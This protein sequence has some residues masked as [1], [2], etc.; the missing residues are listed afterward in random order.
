LNDEQDLQKKED[1]KFFE[2]SLDMIRKKVLEKEGNFE[3][4]A[5]FMALVGASSKRISD[6][7]LIYEVLNGSCRIETRRLACRKFA[8]ADFLEQARAVSYGIPRA[9]ES[10]DILLNI[11]SIS[12][13]EK[14]F[15]RVSEKIEDLNREIPILNEN[16]RRREH[17]VRKAKEYFVEALAEAGKLE[18]ALR[19]IERSDEK[20]RLFGRVSSII[21]EKAY[22]KKEVPGYVVNDTKDIPFAFRC[23]IKSG[24]KENAII[25]VILLL[26]ENKIESARELVESID[27]GVFLANYIK[28]RCYINI[29]ITSKSAGDIEKAFEYAIRSKSTDPKG[30][31][32]RILIETGILLRSLYYLGLALDMALQSGNEQYEIE[33]TL[34]QISRLKH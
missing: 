18:W 24:N 28:A 13:D 9:E 17:Q 21:I 10:F 3:N 20:G 15:L 7:D 19:E 1:L 5:R 22:A 31:S 25:A 4:K 33:Y 32:S 12:K 2:R 14:D 11:A 26:G 6:F 30:E 23:S 8:E 34:S 29:A 16:D 27:D